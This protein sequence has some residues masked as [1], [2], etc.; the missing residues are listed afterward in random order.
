[1]KAIILAAGLGTR[2]K[3]LTLKNSK[4]IAEN[5]KYNNYRIFG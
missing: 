1:M 2:L 4:T 5:S 3:D